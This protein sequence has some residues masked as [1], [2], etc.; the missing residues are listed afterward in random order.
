MTF[1]KAPYNFVPLNR[2]VVSPHWANR[3]SH[4]IPFKHQLSGSFKILIKAHSPLFVQD[5]LGKDTDKAAGKFSQFQNQYFLP[6]STIK[7]MV[8]NVLEVMSFAKLGNKVNN[9]RYAIRDLS[10]AAKAIYLDNFKAKDI[11]AGWLYKKDE[12]YCLEDCGAP[13]RLSHRKLDEHYGTNFSEF[14]QKGKGFDQR[15]DE[16]KA[17]QFKYKLF[18]GHARGNRFAQY[19]ES[20]GRLLYEVATKGEEGTIV[21]T[22]QPGPRF[23]ARN[24]RWTGHHLE[25]IFFP[26]KRTVTIDP[27]VVQ[28]FEFAYHEKDRPR[29]SIDYAYWREELK[30]GNKIPVFFRKDNDGVVKDF[31]LSF[32][33]KMPYRHSVKESI[34]LYQKE[35]GLDLAEAIFGYVDMETKEALKGRVHM[36]HAF[37]KVGTAQLDGEKSE[38]LSG[39]KAS[40][41]PNYIRQKIGED[42]RVQGRYRTF[43]DKDHQIAGWKRYPIHRN[44]VRSNPKPPGTSDKVL[45]KFVPLKEGAVFEGMVHYHNLRKEE[46]GALLSAL[47]FH[48]TPD[49]FHSVGM[50]KPLGYGKTSIE[51]QGL[52]GEMSDYLRSYEAFMNVMLGNTTPEWHVTP[53]ITELI[54]MVSEQ[55]NQGNSELAYMKLGVRRGENAF[56]EAKQRKAMEALDVYS[57]LNGILSKKGGTYVS[58]EDIATAKVQ[59]DSEKAQFANAA[60]PKDQLEAYATQQ[61]QVFISA[62]EDKKVELLQAIKARRAALVT[63]AAEAKEAKEKAAQVARKTE[64][65]EAAK[66]SKPNLE[67]IKPEDRNAFDK[68]KKLIARYV[69]NYHGKKYDK[70]QKEFPEGGVLPDS[71]HQETI[72][73]V[74]MII[75]NAK[76]NDQKK[77]KK[78]IAKNANVK[79]LGEWIGKEAAGKFLQEL[80]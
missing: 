35:K 37:A 3:I 44:G 61:K 12:Q 26:V 19:G 27:Q 32:L 21:F 74:Q 6:G 34:E 28:N 51:I 45:T 53:Q 75:Q 8:R 55:N 11:F 31:G 47:T 29:W 64:R 9:H 2:E 17:A 71:F 5:G 33:Y 13:G 1:I 70:L 57:K 50:A 68:L 23:I 24:S 52:K 4:D 56:V 48:N 20:A 40:Y 60:N 36:G 65:M 72:E 15:K 14:F 25:F 79:K 7:G 78:T 38:V 54:T 67:S 30:K 42:G 43:M 80:G 73:L 69:E 77:W 18:N 76:P 10:P 22:G 59:I 62:F 46:L 58:P 49:T 16:Q 39:P 63:A 41:Y 66:S